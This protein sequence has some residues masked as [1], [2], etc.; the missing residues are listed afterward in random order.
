[1]DNALTS[2]QTAAFRKRLRE[3]RAEVIEAIRQALL[4]SDNEHYIE[5]AGAVHD[6]GEE[7]VA[8]QLSEMANALIGRQVSEVRAIEEALQRIA[9]GTYGVCVDCNKPI[10]MERLGVSPAARRCYNCQA[11]YEKDHAGAGRP[12][13]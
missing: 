5:L 11:R 3:R 13:L 7:S 9:V 8:D 6:T 12:S 2:E 10:E 4:K 1:M